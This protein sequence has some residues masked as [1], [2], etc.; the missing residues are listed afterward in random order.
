MQATKIPCMD[1]I[2]THLPSFFFVVR[3]GKVGEKVLTMDSI[4]VLDVFI[5]GVSFSGLGYQFLYKVG[6]Y[7]DYIIGV[8]TLVNG[9]LGVVTLL[10]NRRYD[11]SPF[12]TG[13]SPPC[14]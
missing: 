11:I 9:Q 8:R 5:P 13:R 4:I 12:M 2:G 6:P 3:T 7:Q 14:R 10:I 1:G